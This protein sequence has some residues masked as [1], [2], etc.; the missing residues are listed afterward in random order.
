MYNRY[1]SSMVT[2]ELTLT[3]RRHIKSLHTNNICKHCYLGDLDFIAVGVQNARTI[4][5]HHQTWNA[6]S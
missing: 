3:P 2:V 6:V 1:T 5:L 4:P